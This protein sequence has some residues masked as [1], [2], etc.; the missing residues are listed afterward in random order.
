MGPIR[1]DSFSKQVGGQHYQN[2]IQPWDIISAWKLDSWRGNVIKYI[3]RA[4]HKNGREDLE[5]AMHYLEFLIENYDEVI[6][7]VR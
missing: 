6:N 1:I 4:P 5:K 2:D 7:D 3:L